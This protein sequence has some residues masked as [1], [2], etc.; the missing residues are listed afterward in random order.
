[1]AVVNDDP[2]DVFIQFTFV[3]APGYGIGA[4]AADGVELGESGYLMF[5][6]PL[7]GDVFECDDEI[8]R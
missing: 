3:F 7:P 6:L 8:I 5:G 1:M 2:A 4:M